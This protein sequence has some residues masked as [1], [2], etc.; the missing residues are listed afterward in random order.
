M[1]GDQLINYFLEDGNQ[2]KENQW[3][4]PEPQFGEITAAEKIDLVIVP[5][6]AFDLKGNRV[7]YGKGYYDRFLKQCRPDCKKVGLS[8]FEPVQKIIDVD[9]YDVKLTQCITPEKSFVF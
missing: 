4:I 6:L 9:D 7:G 2:I 5:L 8:F 1:N 3:N